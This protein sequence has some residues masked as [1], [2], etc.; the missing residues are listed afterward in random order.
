[1][2]AGELGLKL[3]RSGMAISSDDDFGQGT[4]SYG[5]HN[6]VGIYFTNDVIKKDSNKKWLNKS[7]TLKT[8]AKDDQVKIFY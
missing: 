4:I 1:V 5:A 8:L 2:A 7:R 6:P 3:D